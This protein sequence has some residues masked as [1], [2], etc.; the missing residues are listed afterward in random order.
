MCAYRT[1]GNRKL[2]YWCLSICISPVWATS[3]Q[4][5]HQNAEYAK[6]SELGLE[7]L[8][9]EPWNH[10]LRFLVAD[11]LERSGNTSAAASQFATLSGTPYSEMA[12]IRLGRILASDKPADAAS[13]YP[14]P[15]TLIAS[16]A[17]GERAFEIP[18]RPS[19]SGLL[20]E[21][22]SRRQAQIHAKKSSQ[23]SP[24]SPEREKVVNLAIEGD[25]RAVA[26][27]GKKLI[28]E[29]SKDD[30]LRLMVANSLAWTGD[31]NQAIPVYNA[32]I[33]DKGDSEK[34]NDARVGLGNALRWQ[35][36][37]DLALPQYRQALAADPGLASAREGLEYAERE[38]RPR[39]T[40][41]LG[42][43][44]DTSDMERQSMSINHRWRDR[45]LRTIYEIELGGSHD[46]LA[47]DSINQGDITLRYQ[48]L[49][50]P[51]KPKLWFSAQS[52]PQ[53]YGFGGVQLQ[54]I[55]EKLNF[56]IDRINWGQRALNTRAL[57]HGLSA[58]HLGINGKLRLDGGDIR[59]AAD[60][61]DISDGNTILTTGLKYTPPLR[62][63][64]WQPF[65]GAE[66]REP[67]LAS[68]DYW[69][70]AAGYGSVFA[71][72]KGEWSAS[73]WDVFVE[74]QGGQRMYGDAGS[75]W[76][77][78]GGGRTWVS[79]DIAL[80]LRLW[81]MSSWRDNARYRANLASIT[82]ETLW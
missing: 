31:L 56:E 23:A 18:A 41:T 53:F 60:Y 50:K 20:R 2:L 29:G 71:G 32:I 11:A 73:R 16:N 44:H 37:D 61:Y 65:L 34:V 28:S 57:R 63:G 19:T 75:S 49:D 76:S 79:N 59:M 36:R 46:D 52:T 21:E 82:L 33:R 1:P 3:I 69:S 27:E 8:L 81:N 5:L 39:T 6:A 64:G 58:S 7:R 10:E 43:S 14:T 74:G 77:L 24:S 62:L 38:L 78:S 67:K 54:A 40:L 48:S 80:G 4:E 45:N 9:R 12:K 22:Y 42:R 26:K 66:T 35:G 30:E 51:F 68:L 72:L 15:K 70:P 25:Y 47:G 55:P 13:T 17:Y